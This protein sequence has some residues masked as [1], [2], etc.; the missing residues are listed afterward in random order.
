MIERGDTTYHTID[1]K[2]VRSNRPSSEYVTFEEH[3]F[4]FGAFF[5]Y[6]SSLDDEQDDESVEDQHD[7][8]IMINGHA[9]QFEEVLSFYAGV[10]DD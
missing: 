8:D 5:L 6:A 2:D 10:F 4:G 7:Y 1:Q 3:K 9:Y